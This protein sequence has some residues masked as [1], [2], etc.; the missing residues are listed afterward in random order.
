MHRTETMTFAGT[1]VDIL[2][3]GE[4]TGR[5]FSLLRITNPPGVWTPPHRHLNEEETIYVLSGQVEVETGGKTCS[6]SVGEAMILP[7][8]QAHRLGNAGSETAE[9]LV[10]CTPS[11]FEQ[12]VREA[13]QTGATS[14]PAQVPD[15]EALARLGSLSTRFGIELLAST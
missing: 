6:L 1:L 8:G 10:F 5:Q 2:V 15:A 7:R 12:F 13:G 14:A 9:A 3:T 4:E 11:G